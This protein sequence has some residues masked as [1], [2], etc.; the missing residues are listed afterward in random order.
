MVGDWIIL[1]LISNNRYDAWGLAALA[2]RML[3]IGL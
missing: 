1:G 3:L 2:L